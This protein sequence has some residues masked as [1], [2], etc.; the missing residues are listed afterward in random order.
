MLIRQIP[1][2]VSLV[3]ILSAIFLAIQGETKY[4]GTLL[5]ATGVIFFAFSKNMAESINT[6]N[7]ISRPFTVLTRMLGG[8]TSRSMKLSGIALLVVGIMWTLNP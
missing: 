6:D 2:V 5:A 4:A 1:F 8:G 3:C 7:K